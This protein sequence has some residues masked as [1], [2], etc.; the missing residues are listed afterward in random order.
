MPV[1]RISHTPILDLTN[2]LAFHETGFKTAGT[3]P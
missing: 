3:H 2:E 1:H